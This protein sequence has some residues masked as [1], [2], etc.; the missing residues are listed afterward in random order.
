M[1]E[2][3]WTMVLFDRSGI[4]GMLRTYAKNATTDIRAA[5]KLHTRSTGK[6]RPR[7]VINPRPIW[8]S[9][10]FT[11]KVA[12]TFITQTTCNRSAIRAGCRSQRR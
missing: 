11:R 12:W 6:S 1:T 5:G 4:H 2:R 3:V 9:E 7:Y 10:D 8:E